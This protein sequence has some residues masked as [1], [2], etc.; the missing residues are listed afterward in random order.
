MNVYDKNIKTSKSLC[1]NF[2]KIINFLSIFIIMLMLF[3]TMKTYTRMHM[4]S[5][6]NYALI[7]AVTKFD[8]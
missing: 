1:S 8:S 2:F 7:L 3:I 6:A 4:I 5:D